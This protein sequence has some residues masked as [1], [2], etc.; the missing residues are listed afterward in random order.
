M[1]FAC[2]LCV[3]AWKHQH[4]GW[5][6][7]YIR[8]IDAASIYIYILSSWAINSDDAF[9]FSSSSSYSIFPWSSISLCH[10]SVV[11]YHGMRMIQ[12][13][14]CKQNQHTYKIVVILLLLF[15]FSQLP[16]K[17]NL[18]CWMILW[19]N[20]YFPWEARLR[21]NTLC[22]CVSLIVFYEDVSS[23]CVPLIWW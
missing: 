15:F 5:I 23:I 18:C 8:F 21:T 9:F 7:A 20:Y 4:T 14:H 1:L 12:L 17:Q 10:R 11:K 19:Q 2:V 22:V 6:N 16:F 3:F 13:I